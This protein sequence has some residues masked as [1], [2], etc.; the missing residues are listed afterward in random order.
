MNRYEKIMMFGVLC[1]FIGSV[2]STLSIANAVTYYGDYNHAQLIESNGLVRKWMVYNQTIIFD[3]DIGSY[4]FNAISIL[5]HGLNT[6]TYYSG[7]KSYYVITST[8][9]AFEIFLNGARD[10]SAYSTFFFAFKGEDSETTFNI[11]VQTNSTS[12]YKYSFT[13]NSSTWRYIEIPYS[14]F[15]LEFTPTWSNINNIWMF[16]NLSDNVKYNFDYIG[17]RTSNYYEI[18]NGSE[19]VY[20]GDVNPDISD[21]ITT[22]ETPIEV[23]TNYTWIILLTICIFSVILGIIGVITVPIISIFGLIISLSII[24]NQIVNGDISNGLMNSIAI[25][26]TVITAICFAVAWSKNR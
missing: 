7:L 6:T 18:W 21:F 3:D 16:Y 11:A 1:I 17:V 23:E 20:G 2:L 25:C 9:P 12:F 4:T 19:K 14:N 26:A 15:G 22:T 8:A 24:L 13:D 10:L 5:G